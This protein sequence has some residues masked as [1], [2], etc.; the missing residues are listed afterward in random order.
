MTLEEVCDMLARGKSNVPSAAA[1][2]GLS[3]AEMKQVFSQ[4]AKRTPADPDA[5]LTDVDPSWPYWT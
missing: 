2:C 4:Y 3:W 1:R 5:Y